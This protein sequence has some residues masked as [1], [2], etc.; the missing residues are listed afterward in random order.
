MPAVERPSSTTTPDVS[1]VPPTSGPGAETLWIPVIAVV[2]AAIVVYHRAL[3]GFFSQ[4]DFLGLARASGLAPRLA[5]VWRFLSHQAYFDLMRPLVGLNPVS[6]HLVSLVVHCAAVTV[7]WL[8]LE[9]SVSR[10]A[11]TVGAVCFAVHPASF[12]ALYWI[13]AVGDSLALLFALKTLFL[14]ARR[15][16][17]R[18]LALPAFALSLLAKES[19]LL[20]PVLVFAMGVPGSGGGA[21]TG[22]RR[23]ALRDP[24]VL[25]L[26]VLALLHL[27]AFVTGNA[28]DV[29][30]GLAGEA[31][32]ALGI[33]ANL[34]QNALTYIGWTA[35]FFLPTVRAFSDANDPGVYA[36][37]VAALVVWIAGLAL[38][39]LRERGWA[40]GGALWLTFVLPV[41]PLKNHTYHYYL[42][43][44]L[45]GAAWCV[46]A[47]FDA[48]LVALPRAM[49]ARVVWSVAAAFAALL[50]LNG[51]LLVQKI[52]TAPFMLPGL[53]ADA[54]V[55]R[56]RIAQNVSEALSA[57]ELPS[58]VTLYFWSPTAA[59]IGPQGEALTSP[60]EYPTYW[61]TNVRHALMGG[62]AVRVLFPQVAD[63]RFVREYRPV[64]EGD[65][66]AVYLPD[67]ELRVK[68]SAEVDSILKS[69][70]RPR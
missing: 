14:L 49:S 29:R 35:N 67:G 25:G 11:A 24:V 65:R 59:S 31:P 36:W 47:A 3:V 33:G 34:W 46:A 21:P 60:S 18:W 5:G 26:C 68:T 41:L 22:A 9:R 56:G 19:T 30:G 23:P 38:R 57:V 69:L 40:F 64:P 58:G 16:R 17:W 7:L 50:T 1:D 43:A 12:T 8:L 51:Y 54:M 27:T 32:Y 42:Y 28:F 66:Y 55:D 53:H 6:Y 15:D 39:P 44:P 10:A 52:E 70:P 62:L 61:E 20:L 13:S 63:V 45:A 4:D 37:A 48:A 2:L